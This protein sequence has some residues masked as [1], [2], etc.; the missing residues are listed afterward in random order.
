MEMKKYLIAA[1]LV[2]GVSGAF[3]SCHE[4]DIS[5]STVEQKIQAF[6]DVFVDAFGRPDPN[7]SWGFGEPIVVEEG[8]TRSVIV[9]GNEWNDIPQV[10]ADEKQA[11]YAWVNKPKSDIPTE[12]YRE[13]SPIN[14]P[15]FYVTHIWGKKDNENDVNAHYTAYN[16][17]AVWGSAHMD[18]LQISKSSDR[19]GL[20]GVTG[21][22][23]A[24]INS[25]WDHANNFNAGNNQDWEGSTKFEN[26]GTLNFAYHNSEDS[27]YHDKWIIV[28]GYY[29]TED[30]RFAGQY[31]VCFDFIGRNPN[32]YTT[33]YDAK[34]QSHSVPGVYKTLTEAIGQTATDGAVVDETWRTTGIEVNQGNMIVDANEYYTDW[35][36]RL[37]N[38]GGTYI[39]KVKVLSTTGGKTTRV[40]YSGEQVVQSGRVFCEDIVSARYALEDLDYNDVVFDAA[41]VHNYRKLVSTRYDENNNLIE[42]TPENPNPKIEYDFTGIENQENGFNEY[43]A[44]VCLLAAGGTLPIAMKIGNYINEDVHNI[45]GGNSPS[46]MINT[47]IKDEREIVNMAEVAAYRPAANLTHGTGDNE[48]D[49]FVGISDI[50]SGIELFVQYGNV[51]AG[52]SSKYY[53]GQENCVASAKFMVP[54]GTPWAKERTNIATAYPQF[55]DWVREE[56]D[57]NGYIQHPF[58]EFSAGDE[59]IYLDNDLDK[60][61]PFYKQGLDPKIWTKDK[62]VNNSGHEDVINLPDIGGGGTDEFDPKDPVIASPSGTLLYDFTTSVGP[63]YLYTGHN[64]NAD[65]ST[66]IKVGSTI[67]VYGVSIDG[68]EVKCNFND[69]T[70]NK[71]ESAGCGYIDITVTKTLNIREYLTFS[72]KNFT[73][74]YVTLLGDSNTLWKGNK[75]IGYNREITIAKEQFANANKNSRIVFTATHISGQYPQIHIKKI[76]QYNE[77]QVA[78]VFAANDWP[79]SVTFKIGDHISVLKNNDICIQGGGLTMT[80]IELIP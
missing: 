9:N 74:T 62:F 52:I 57:E 3:V 25:N 33:I 48:T 73:I 75:N 66:S 18:N 36:V 12:S 51:A 6:E 80:K 31:Y 7:H 72:G 10:T 58:W 29:I 39:P 59:Y 11:I 65:N 42:S 69:G 16:N 70:F 50:N 46:V 64:V 47:L 38:A 4:D 24:T 67:R 35:I 22:K 78:Q 53:D 68:W 2:V 44:K 76:G 14:W 79:G 27:R 34:G 21:S 13:V 61:K 45:L 43:Y 19:L 63:G 23:D 40:I 17:G 8:I 49:K 71:Y 77:E 26:W 5:T 60:D 1:A 37:V 54:L 55:K 56:T 41:I 15:N 32:T 28:D 20:D 30:H